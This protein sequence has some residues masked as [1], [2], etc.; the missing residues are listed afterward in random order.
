MMADRGDLQLNEDSDPWCR[1]GTDFT[2]VRDEGRK[3]N[4]EKSALEPPSHR[5]WHKSPILHC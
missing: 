4:V 1:P 3:R 2:S 5:L